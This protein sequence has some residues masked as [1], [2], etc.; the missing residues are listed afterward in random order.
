M[1]TEGLHHPLVR[2]FAIDAA[3]LVALGLATPVVL[4]LQR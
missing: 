4:R 2:L 3:F 1:R